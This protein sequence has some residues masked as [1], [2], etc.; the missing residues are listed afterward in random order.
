MWTECPF[1]FFLSLT[2]SEHKLCEFFQASDY[3]F[4]QIMVFVLCVF[5][6]YLQSDFWLKMILYNIT[7]ARFCT[8]LLQSLP[9]GWACCSTSVMYTF[10]LLIYG[11]CVVLICSQLHW[12]RLI[13]HLLLLNNV[14]WI[15]FKA[16]WASLWH[17]MLIHWRCNEFQN[18]VTETESSIGSCM[19]Q[20]FFLLTSH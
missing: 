1:F 7:F 5:S 6:P 10:L 12:N 11:D 13:G 17:V 18:H 2:L 15:L 4:L 3:W 19:L 9:N 8:C 20:L 16:F 14:I